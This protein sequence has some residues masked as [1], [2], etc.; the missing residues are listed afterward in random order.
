MFSS[1]E[2]NET[3][4][5]RNNTTRDVFGNYL[6]LQIIAYVR[7]ISAIIASKGKAPFRGAFS[8]QLYYRVRNFIIQQHTLSYVQE[9]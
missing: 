2:Q 8:S 1:Q 4:Y 3:L 9:Q 7:S 6:C 5:F